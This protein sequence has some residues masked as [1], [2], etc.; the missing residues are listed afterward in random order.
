MGNSKTG[1]LFRIIIIIALLAP[2][3]FFLSAGTAGDSPREVQEKLVLEFVDGLS[4]GRDFSEVKHLFLSI[5]DFA[6]LVVELKKGDMPPRKLRQLEGDRNL[7][8]QKKMLKLTIIKIVKLWKNIVL[9]IKEKHLKISY[10]D[11]ESRELVKNGV[12]R[13]KLNLKFIVSKNGKDNEV[14]KNIRVMSIGGK[15]KIVRIFSRI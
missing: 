10:Q 11:F 8:R 14:R 12:T 9:R 3:S 2:R 13:Y 5:D 4:Q 1:I 7:K 15:L 6:A